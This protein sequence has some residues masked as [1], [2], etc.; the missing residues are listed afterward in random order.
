MG[1]MTT[2]DDQLRNPTG[3]VT[4]DPGHPLTL[5]GLAPLLAQVWMAEE[6]PRSLR[7]EWTTPG[8]TRVRK[9]VG[10]EILGMASNAE[11]PPAY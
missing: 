2:V 4:V 7:V 3:T 6:Q 5:Y 9:I 10:A 1:G 11:E 8:G